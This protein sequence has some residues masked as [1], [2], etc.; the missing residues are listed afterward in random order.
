MWISN[1]GHVFRVRG[2]RIHPSGVF[3]NLLMQKKRH[4]SSKHIKADAGN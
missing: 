1:R 2:I 4:G 3:S